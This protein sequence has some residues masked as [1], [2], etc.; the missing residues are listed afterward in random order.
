MSE[1]EYWGMGALEYWVSNTSLHYSITP[2]LWS[3]VAFHGQTL[4]IPVQHSSLEIGHLLEAE[5]G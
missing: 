3:L 4:V 2:V 1:P 5:A